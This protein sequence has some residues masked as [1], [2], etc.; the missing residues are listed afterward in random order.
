MV[1]LNWKNLDRI[2][3]WAKDITKVVQSYLN[4]RKWIYNK[5]EFLLKYPQST[6]IIF[7]SNGQAMIKSDNSR[8]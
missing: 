2:F 8:K 5:A 3:E 7:D 1:G 6:K 4:M